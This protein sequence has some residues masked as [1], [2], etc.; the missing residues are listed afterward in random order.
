M[1]ITINPSDLMIINR[2]LAHDAIPKEKAFFIDD[3]GKYVPYFKRQPS[4]MSAKDTKKDIE[5]SASKLLRQLHES[6]GNNIRRK[7]AS[8]SK[9]VDRHLKIIIDIVTKYSTFEQLKSYAPNLLK[10]L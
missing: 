1:K 4:I 7:Y 6:E 5:V 3:E 9:T 8:E 2:A 10:I